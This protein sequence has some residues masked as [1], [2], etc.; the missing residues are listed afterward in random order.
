MLAFAISSREGINKKRESCFKTGRK[1]AFPLPETLKAT[2]LALA[3]A[4]KN[5][6]KKR[7][8]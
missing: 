8:N 4:G 1:S 7:K 2:G 5:R 3:R 6:K